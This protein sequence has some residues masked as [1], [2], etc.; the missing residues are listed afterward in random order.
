M[1]STGQLL[2]MARKRFLPLFARYVSLIPCNPFTI[3][4]VARFC[5]EE[6]A[7]LCGSCCVA[8]NLGGSVSLCILVEAAPRSCKSRLYLLAK[9]GNRG[10][11]PTVQRGFALLGLEPSAF[12]ASNSA[13]QG[14]LQ[15]AAS[16]CIK[17]WLRGVC[18]RFGAVSNFHCA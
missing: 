17:V 5:A 1:V 15:A 11:H 16:V 8:P 9:L 4:P 3:L 12:L 13:A 10:E 6:R 14:S 18:P 7:L 2:K